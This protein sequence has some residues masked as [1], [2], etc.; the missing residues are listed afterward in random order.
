[1]V[2][3]SG[4]DWGMTD[5][6]WFLTNDNLGFFEIIFGMAVD[7][8]TVIESLGVMGKKEVAGWDEKER[9]FLDWHGEETFD[10]LKLNNLFKLL[11]FLDGLTFL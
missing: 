3:A 9:F 6:A 8:S 7:G 2:S 4:E 11:T 5:I 10:W 1:M